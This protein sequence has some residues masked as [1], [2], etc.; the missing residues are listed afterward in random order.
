MS[1][2]TV[3]VV[4]ATKGRPAILKRLIDLLAFQSTPAD[5][6]FVIGASAT[7]V[8][9]LDP[10][11]LNLTVRIGRPGSSPQRNDGLA[12]VGD[13]F[14]FVAFF[15][16]DFVPSKFWLERAVKLFQTRTDIAGL[17]GAVLADGTTTAGIEFDAATAIVAERDANASG[18][19]E[20]MEGPGP[21]GCNMAFRVEAIRGISFDERLPL[22]AW[23]EDSDFGAQV[24]RRGITARATELWG[25]HMGNKAGR[26]RGVRIGYSQI[27]NPI[28]LTLKGTL[29]IGFTS[30]TMIR[31]FTANLVHLVSPEPFIDRAGRL[32]GNLLAIG[33]VLCGRIRPE[34]VINL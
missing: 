25:V 12:L 8:A 18:Q 13:H 14:D 28:Y 19:F 30:R 3:A 29:T 34:R 23:L 27:A 4:I 15:D 31:N 22:Y 6:I 24:A 2:Q 9:E 1:K 10:K 21:Y 33:D 32:W 11:Q 20:I 5:H 26:E 16:D 17:T 7:D